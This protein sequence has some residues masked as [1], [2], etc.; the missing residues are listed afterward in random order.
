M[1][2][3]ALGGRIV[4]VAGNV[5]GRGF[6]LALFAGVSALTIA[7]LALANPQGG[8]VVQGSA[9]ITTPTPTKTQIDQTTDKAII[10]WQSFNVGQGESAVF[11]QPNSASVTLNRIFDQDPSIIAGLVSANGRLILI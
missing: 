6:K 3:G 2:R 9:T 7:S 8:E 4:S 1:M 10:N 11:N 5:S